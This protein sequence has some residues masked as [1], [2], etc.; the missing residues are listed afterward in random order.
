LIPIGEMNPLK[1]L[2]K[3]ENRIQNLK[4]SSVPHLLAISGQLMA[5]FPSPILR[6][7]LKS[8][9]S[10]LGGAFLTSFPGPV[11]EMLFYGTYPAKEISFGLNFFM[12]TRGNI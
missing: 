3:I 11:D 9:S 1:R 2:R 4:N 5:S 7:V 10:R 6:F 12:G 8:L